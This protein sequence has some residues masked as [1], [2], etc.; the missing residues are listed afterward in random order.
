MKEL[1]YNSLE[2]SELV[3]QTFEFWFSDNEHIRSPFPSYIHNDLK[4]IATEKFFAWAKGLNPKAK[5]ELN[6]EMVGEKFEEIIFESASHLVKTEDERITLLYPFLPRIGDPIQNEG[7]EE[8]KVIDRK[9]VKEG[10]HS[11]LEVTLEKV[12]A[13]EKWKTRFELPA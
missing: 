11:F 13:K 8:S 2:S 3:N 10:D 7:E 5:D 4:R 12:A 9:M 1:V 6:D